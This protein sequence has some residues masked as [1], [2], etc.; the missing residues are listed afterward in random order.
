M[1]TP[2]PG[3]PRPNPV[4]PEAVP[5]VAAVTLP[6]WVQVALALVAA[7]TPVLVALQALGL[8]AA[9]HAAD[10]A[11]TVKKTVTD[12]KDC[13]HQL[14]DTTGAT[15]SGCSL[16]QI[17]T[18]VAQTKDQLGQLPQTLVPT[19]DQLRAALT[20]EQLQ[21]LLTLAVEKGVRVPSGPAGP[22]GPAGSTGPPGPP[23]VAAPTTTSTTPGGATTT[24]RPAPATTTTT[25]RPRPTTTTTRPSCDPLS[26]ILGRC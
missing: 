26:S 8:G 3:P 18:D 14:G 19:L 15:S 13:V 11:S 21:R 17:A 1:G 6:R 9:N 7:V 10:T 22:P 24:T 20:P 4:V 25:T 5:S 2:P 23:A 16:D 12:V